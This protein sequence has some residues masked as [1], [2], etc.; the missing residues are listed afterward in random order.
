MK[1]RRIINQCYG[2]PLRRAVTLFLVLSLG[3]CQSLAADRQSAQDQVDSFWRADSIAERENAAQRLAV[4]TA[5]ISTL[6]SWL[7]AGPEYSDKVPVGTLEFTRVNADGMHFP[8]VVLVPESYDPSR[9]YPVEFM[10]H[11]GVSRPPWEAGQQWWR[12][13]YESLQNPDRI[14]IVP[15]SWNEA[16][17]WFANQAENLPAI[18]EQVKQD[19][20]VDENRVFL[21]GVSDGGTG[22]YF[23]A[24][25]QPTHW[26]AFLP[27]IGHMAVLRNREAGG[28]H[29]L[30]FENLTAKPLYIVN[31][32]ADPLYPAY[33]VRPYIEYLQQAGVP[34]VFK[35]IFE[36]G[37]NTNWMPDELPFIEQFK[38]DNPRD[39][40]PENVQWITETTA[41]YTRNHWLRIDTLLNEGRPG[42][43]EVS[44]QDNLFEIKS[45]FVNTFTLLL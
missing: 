1:N 12:R 13:G 7:K 38:Q 23:F 39:P 43:V 4:S 11:G 25:R 22:A 15:A 10:L 40:L 45:T 9:K 27:Y 5:D 41:D 18:L 17:W 14:T 37:H 2:S 19:Y 44:R 30:F 21:A 36:G 24:F 33:A 16:F 3:S 28:G 35:A 8:Y 42:R 32:E 6:Y 31:G 34:H 20:N 26:A 29:A